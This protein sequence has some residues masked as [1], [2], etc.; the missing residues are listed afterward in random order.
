MGDLRPTVV[1]LGIALPIIATIAVGLRVQA[2]RV[3]KVSLGVDDYTIFI[4]LVTKL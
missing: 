1:G 2:R 3:V 4:A